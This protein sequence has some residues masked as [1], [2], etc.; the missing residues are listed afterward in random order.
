MR[1]RQFIA[2]LGS[3]AA[4]PIV[5]RAQQPKRVPRVAVLQAAAESDSDGQSRVN[6]FREG[7][8]ALGWSN[9]PNV[10]WAGGETSKIRGLAR[11]LLDLHPGLGGD[12]SF[13]Q[14]DPEREPRHSNRIHS[15]YRSRRARTGR[16]LGTAGSQHYGL[17]GFRAR[18]RIQVDAG[19]QR[20]CAGDKARSGHLQP[21]YG[22]N[23]RSRSLH[24][25][26]LRSR[27]DHQGRGHQGGMSNFTAASNASRRVTLDE[28]ARRL[29][30][31]CG[32]RSLTRRPPLGL[33]TKGVAARKS[34]ATRP[35]K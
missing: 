21:G 30:R 2:G 11:E 5:V 4:W 35:Q 13:G 26:N 3:A 10:R 14:R 16:D 6:A 24:F 15:G 31:P 22:D 20:D 25:T 8:A 1:R 29:S 32:L 27:A 19:T 34:R 28:I 23:P 9:G 18:N 7:L 12:H 17:Y 33:A